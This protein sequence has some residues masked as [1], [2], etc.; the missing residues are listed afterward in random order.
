VARGERVAPRVERKQKKEV[1]KETDKEKKFFFPHAH[2]FFS[3][4]DIRNKRRKKR[5]ENQNAGQNLI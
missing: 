4:R 3:L 2:R 1:W 5:E